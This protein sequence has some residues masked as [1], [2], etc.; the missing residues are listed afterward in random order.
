MKTIY[1]PWGREEWLELNDKYCYKR[2]YINKGY[3]TSFQYHEK[4]L[5]TNYL[6]T[7]NAE[8]WLENDKGIVEKKNIVEGD[9]FTVTPLKKHRI[10][11]LTD[12]I[13]QEVSTPEV[14]DVIRI[15]DDTHRNNGCIVSEHVVAVQQI[16]LT[17]P[18]TTNEVTYKL[19]NRV[20]KFSSNS[21]ISANRLRSGL[22][23]GDFAPRNLIH[24]DL[25]LIYDWEEGKN[26]Y[27]IDSFEI[28][29]KFLNVLQKRTKEAKIWSDDP[30]IRT[31]YEQKVIV[32]K[33]KILERYGEKFVNSKCIINNQLFE[34]VSFYLD[35]INSE[36]FQNH[37]LYSNFHGDL[38]FTNII[39]NDKA[40][41]FVGVDWADSFVGCLYG[42]DIYYDLSKF[43]AGCLFP[44]IYFHHP[45]QVLCARD[46]NTINYSYD[47]SISLMKMTKRYEKWIMEN[48][49][50][51]IKIKLITGLIFVC[52]SPLHDDIFS[53]VFLC[54]GLELLDSNIKLFNE[55]V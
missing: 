47:R 10:L 31:F 16:R 3:R 55:R 28:Y 22:R 46:G 1:K 53:Q 42:G 4:K 5:E 41:R 2:I 17:T 21:Q 27:E 26:L 54:K 30:L 37:S 29:I 44:F 43:Y 34:S 20:F 40:D 45:N 49:F 33:E 23:L 11:A 14:D 19:G 9:F 50:D 18:K 38:H 35:Q 48:D 7:G 8:L 24:E 32:R 52:I 13:L 25:F 39:Y 6:I 15:D 51:L 12:I 36:M